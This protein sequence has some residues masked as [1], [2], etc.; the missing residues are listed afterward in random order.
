VSSDLPSILGVE[1][2]SGAVFCVVCANFIHDVSL[3][4][5][6]EN[7]LLKVGEEGSAHEYGEDVSDNVTEEIDDADL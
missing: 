6:R 1:A 3:E 2:V 7:V 5:I 4:R